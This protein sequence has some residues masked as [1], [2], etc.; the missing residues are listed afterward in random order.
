MQ[1]RNFFLNIIAIIT[2]TMLSSCGDVTEEYSRRPCRVIIE[3]INDPT[4]NSALNQMAPGVFCMIQQTQKGG[5]INYHCTSNQGL[6]SDI[7][8]TELDRRRNPIVGLN[9]GIIVGFGSLDQT[10]FAY[11]RECPNCFDPDAIPVK[12][13]PLRMTNIGHAIC[14]ICKREYDM[15]SRGIVVKGEPGKKMTRFHA[16][17][18]GPNG[19]LIVQ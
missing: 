4:L 5:A 13:K 6:E 14:D 7:P 16:H 18:T 11:D 19:A 12:S 8:W 15:N 9:D 1:K 17:T 2:F 10:F 3:N